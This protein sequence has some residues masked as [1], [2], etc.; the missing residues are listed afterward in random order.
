MSPAAA[1]PTLDIPELH[2]NLD[3]HPRRPSTNWPHPCS[4]SFLK[5][6]SDVPPGEFFTLGPEK[7]QDA[8][9]FGF[10][11]VAFTSRGVIEE[12]LSYRALSVELPKQIDIRRL[13]VHSRPITARARY[14]VVSGDGF[15]A[16]FS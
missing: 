15:P 14:H 7:N 13:R 9:N 1:L 16:A 12:R 2:T 3:G 6:P 11:L 4:W 8:I 5:R 10:R